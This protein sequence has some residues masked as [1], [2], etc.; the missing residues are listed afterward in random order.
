MIERGVALC[1][2]NRS[3]NLKEIVQAILNTVHPETRVVVCDDGSTDDTPY[4]MTEFKNVLYLRGP[5]RG[6]AANKNRALWALQDC[7]FIAM[8]EDDLLPTTKGWFERYQNA[9]LVS[10]IHHFCRV[11]DKLVDETVPEFSAWMREK[12]YTPIYGPSPRGDFT[13]ITNKVIQKVGGF[14]PQFKG[15]GYA[16]GEWSGRVA[17]AGLISHPLKW[18]DLLEPSETFE[19]KGDTEGGRWLEDKVKIKQQMKDNHAIAK[20][21]RRSKYIYH[22]LTLS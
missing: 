16:H 13:F 3:S 21:L 14:H 17:K 18:V 2:Y 9:A 11:Q 8:F 22:S 7:A 15:V 1:T 20:Q 4:L 6:V 19:Q 5:N 12:G 10:D